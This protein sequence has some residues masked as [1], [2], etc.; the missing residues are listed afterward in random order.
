MRETAKDMQEVLEF[1]DKAKQDGVNGTAY[2]LEIDGQPGGPVVG[3]EDVGN[4]ATQAVR[5]LL[6]T[7]NG[8]FYYADEFTDM[9]FYKE[10]LKQ[11]DQLSDKFPVERISQEEM[12]KKRSAE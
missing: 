11:I 5:L 6:E 8:S 12:E 3:D 4:Q 9:E 2:L 7:G 1:A 10:A